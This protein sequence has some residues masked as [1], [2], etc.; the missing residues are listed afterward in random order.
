ME[1]YRVNSKHTHSDSASIQNFVLFSGMSLD[2]CRNI[3]SRAGR[4][5]IA[6]RETIFVEGDPVR[7][8]ILV[9]TGS[10]K[11]S[12]LGQDGS[13]AILRLA[14]PGDV[15]GALGLL[16]NG[17]HFSTAQTLHSCQTIVWDATTFEKLAETFPMLQ[18]NLRHILCTRLQELEQRFREMSTER[19]A[20]RLARELGRL[21]DQVGRPVEGAIEISLSREELAQMIGTTLFTVSRLLSEW[22][23]RGIVD[24]RRGVVLVRDLQGLANLADAS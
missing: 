6:A 11:I 17:A 23:Q 12:Q 14:G 22:G 9:L 7:E 13:E 2:V 8:V 5:E 20:A 4:R 10:V 1:P 16:A 24:P 19:V 15:V 21:L 18:R 3:V